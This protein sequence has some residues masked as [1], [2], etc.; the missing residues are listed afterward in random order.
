VVPAHSHTHS[1]TFPHSRNGDTTHEETRVEAE[2]R[3][4]RVEIPPRSQRREDVNVAAGA[5]TSV[6]AK[7]IAPRCRGSRSRGG[8]DWQIGRHATEACSS[9]G[10][11]FKRQRSTGRHNKR[12][13]AGRPS[14]FFDRPD[15][16]EPRQR[17]PTG[18]HASAPV[19]VSAPAA[20]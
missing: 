11:T 5:E 13:L 18:V 12:A 16:E 6:C 20:E 8:H 10:A 4:Q 17:R 15:I 1:L 9:G 3:S 19:M 14:C 2:S 7:T